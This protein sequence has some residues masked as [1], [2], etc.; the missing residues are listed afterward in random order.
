MTLKKSAITAAATLLLSGAALADI[1]IGISLPLT[2]P[3]SGLG[4][5]V[6]NQIKLWP[7]SIA[8][9]KLKVVVLDD[10]TDWVEVAE[11]FTIS[12]FIQAPKHLAQQ[13]DLP[14]APGHG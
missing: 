7:T 14:A 2:G 11:L 8:G 12:W 13:V 3:A 6:N 5:P 10:A 4:I 1:T 9:E